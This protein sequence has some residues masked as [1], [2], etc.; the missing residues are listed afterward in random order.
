MYVL[1]LSARY[2]EAKM[3]IATVSILPQAALKRDF[4]CGCLDKKCELAM[5]CKAVG[6][7][8]CLCLTFFLAFCSLGFDGDRYED[9]SASV[10]KQ[11][12]CLSQ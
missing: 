1:V 3:A 7:L 11:T 10:T 9:P 8:E 2:D 12:C 6:S 5:A 4:Y